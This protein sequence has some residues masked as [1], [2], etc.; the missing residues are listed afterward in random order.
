MQWGCGHCNSTF[1]IEL[2]T[3]RN[4]SGKVVYYQEL[5][6]NLIICGG[7]VNHP[8]HQKAIAMYLESLPENQ[9][10]KSGRKV[11]VNLGAAVG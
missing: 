2:P 7:D 3:D 11:A 6:E 1:A 9:P 10:R 8:D 5:L 4:P